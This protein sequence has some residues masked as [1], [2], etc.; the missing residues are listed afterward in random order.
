MRF[1][2]I[3]EAAASN[4]VNYQSQNK[5]QFFEIGKYTSLKNSEGLPLTMKTCVTSAM[6]TSHTLLCHLKDHEEHAVKCLSPAPLPELLNTK[7]EY[8]F[9]CLLKQHALENERRYIVA[10]LQTKHKRTG[11]L[12]LFFFSSVLWEMWWSWIGDASI[13]WEIQKDTP[14]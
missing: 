12:A 6:H 7:S 1:I 9:K 5:F 2:F 11:N 8:K 4:K 10:S 14:A 13:Q 3:F